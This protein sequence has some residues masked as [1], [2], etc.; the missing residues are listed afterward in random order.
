MK[1]FL[2]YIMSFAILSCNSE[3][4][5]T[6]NGKFQTPPPNSGTELEIQRVND[7]IEKDTTNYQ[8]PERKDEDSLD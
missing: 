8:P 1:Y 4:D 6:E 7:A 3:D 5:N 2:I